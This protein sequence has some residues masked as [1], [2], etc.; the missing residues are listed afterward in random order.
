M[1]LRTGRTKP[2]RGVF[3]VVYS[4]SFVF[5]FIG[6]L[7]AERGSMALTP[8][9][10]AAH[11]TPLCPVAIP[12]LILPALLRKL[13]I[14][15][16]QIVSGHYGGFWAIFF[17]WL[18]GFLAMGRGW[19]SWGCFFG[20]IDEGFSKVLRKPLLG[21]RRMPG[22]LRVL[23]Y[24]VLLIVVVWSFWTLEP[25]YC[26]WLCPLKLVTEYP[27]VDSPVRYL[28]AI[29]FI[30]LGMGLLVILPI[31][32]KKRT[33]CGLFCPLGAM[34]SLMSPLNPYRIR[35]DP[36]ACKGCRKCEAACPTFSIV[37]ATG[38]ENRPADGIS[39][40][41]PIPM[42]T[43]TCTRCGE[44]ISVCPEGAIDYALVG[45][46]VYRPAAGGEAPWW[47]RLSRAP[48]RILGEIF[49]ARTLFVFTA[50]AFGA[51]LSGGFVT[52]TLA[53]LLGLLVRPILVLFGSG[54]G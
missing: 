4:F 47:K 40:R 19:C 13:L 3:F 15:P 35:I 50:V 46:P 1:I 30:T 34:Q 25:K 27:A 10:I 8:E 14:F 33:Q 52:R 32:T 20:G 44:C 53:G 17:L 2:W 5:I 26:S 37:T 12:Q 43:R 18:V 29:I 49:E 11:E 23:P 48:R 31:L 6:D 39:S 45:V 21:T 41:A 51:T 54:G 16:S 7:I 9:I 22:R 36:D 24:A 28:Q 38:A 42:I